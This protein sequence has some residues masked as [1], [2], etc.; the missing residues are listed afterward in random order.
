MYDFEFLSSETRQYSS[1]KIRRLPSGPLKSTFLLGA[2]EDK[3]AKDKEGEDQK[4]DDDKGE[5]EK[6]GT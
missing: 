2:D 3:D 4:M 6:E 5:D 1:L